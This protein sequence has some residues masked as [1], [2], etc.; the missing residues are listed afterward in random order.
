M[1]RS[2]GFDLDQGPSEE[3][4]LQGA[5]GLCSNGEPRSRWEPLLGSIQV[6]YLE[7][8]TWRES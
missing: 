4:L 1:Q 3:M 5:A 6:L 2:I 7:G 8:R